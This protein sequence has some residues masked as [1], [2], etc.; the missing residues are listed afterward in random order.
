VTSFSSAASSA[1]GVTAL[2]S[3][4]RAAGLLEVNGKL[5][6]VLPRRYLGAF[7]NRIILY[8]KHRQESDFYRIAGAVFSGQ[9]VRLSEGAT[10]DI[11]ILCRLF[12][13]RCRQDEPSHCSRPKIAPA[14]LIQRDHFAAET[15]V[16][17]ITMCAGTLNRTEPTSR[18]DK[19]AGPDR[20]FSILKERTNLSSQLRVVRQLAVLPTCKPFSGA[21]PKAPIARGEQTS[22]GSA[23]EM[24]TSWRLPWDTPNAIETK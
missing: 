24:L 23:G 19:A 21:N 6:A 5:E 13:N 17:S 4:R 10:V 12:Q 2:T 7:K 11:N 9:T 18:R 16:L 15:A 1:A 14:V 22:D 20:S 8:A 3:P